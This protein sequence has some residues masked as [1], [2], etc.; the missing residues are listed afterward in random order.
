[1]YALGRSFCFIYFFFLN[2]YYSADLIDYSTKNQISDIFP[3]LI[4]SLIVSFCIWLIS[5]TEWS[6]IIILIIQII[7]GIGL[8]WFISEKLPIQEYQEVRQLVFSLFK[9]K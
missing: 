5:F 1:M 9:K 8:Y 3:F 6:Y 7:V 4:I 2:S